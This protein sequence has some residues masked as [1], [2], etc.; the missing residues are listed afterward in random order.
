MW[1]FMRHRA[2]SSCSNKRVPGRSN[3]NETKSGWD[4]NGVPTR[5]CL[6]ALDLEWAMSSPKP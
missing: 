1:L 2:P 3:R 6:T 5:A 4:Q